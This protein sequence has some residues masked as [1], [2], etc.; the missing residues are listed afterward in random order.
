MAKYQVTAPN[1]H[2]YEITAPDDAS[3]QDV[4]AQLQNHVAQEAPAKAQPEQSLGEWAVDQG[5]FLGGRLANAAASLPGLPADLVGLQLA[6]M[7]WLAGNKER[8]ANPLEAFSGETIRGAM[9]DYGSQA[10]NAVT[11]S[12]LT[13]DDLAPRAP[14]NTAERFAGNVAD[15]IGYG[16]GPGALTGSSLKAA[17]GGAAGLTAAQEVAPDSV[18]AQVAGALIGHRIPRAIETRGASILPGTRALLRGRTNNIQDEMDAFK[19][20][21]DQTGQPV[22]VM[23]GQ[24]SGEYNM[25]QVID[26]LIARSPGGQPGVLRANESQAKLLDEAV[27]QRASNPTGTQNVGAPSPTAT[28]NKVLN[29]FEASADKFRARQTKI[30]DSL[31]RAI[32]ADTRVPMSNTSRAIADL[33]SRAASDPK[34]AELISDTYVGRVAQALEESKGTLSYQALRALKTDVGETLPKAGLLGDVKAGQLNKLYGALAEDAAQ[35]AKARGVGKTWDRYNKWATEN[36]RRSRQ[37]FDRITKGR[38]Y[39]PEK[40][41]DAVMNLDATSLKMAMKNL[42]PEGRAKVAGQFLF[43]SAKSKA[44]GSAAEDVA[45][46]Y[47]KF[48]GN[49]SEMKQRGTY[50][51]VFGGPEFK[52]LRDTI[53]DLMKVSKSSM[54]ANKVAHDVSGAAVIRGT[55]AGSIFT[56]AATGN[57]PAAAGVFGATFLA[58]AAAGRLLRSK[59]YLNWLAYARQHPNDTRLVMQRLGMVAARD[60]DPETRKALGQLHQVAQ[61]LAQDGAGD[62]M[63][64]TR[65]YPEA[66]GGYPYTVSQD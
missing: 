37:V 16:A 17:A 12:K 46:S 64:H 15:F 29:D 10:I 4:M 55:A 52:P 19:R 54:R 27:A 45:T 11:G 38:E 61:Q 31:E 35:A 58:P 23:P 3:E 59:S 41:S 53:D 9:H 51:A 1:G 8:T 33:K 40:V 5:K 63:Q 26:A 34:V 6:G 18:L 25:Q 62:G 21:S 49:I 36:Y 39:S 20:L 60:R 57:L 47:Q 65:P 13:P 30:E 2:V 48:L 22:S 66:P 14:R 24:L 56:L 43:E 7:D 42:S 50:D 32:G 44:A 28:G